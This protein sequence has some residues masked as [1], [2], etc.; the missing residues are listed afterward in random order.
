MDSVVTPSAPAAAASA[1]APAPKAEAPLSKRLVSL[2]VFRGL[3]IAGMLLVNNPG[4][5]SHLYGP[6]AHAPWHGWT[7]TDLIFPFFLF[8]VGV[9]M[10]FSFGKQVERGADRGELMR[11]AAKRSL[12]LFLLG[13][14]LASFPWWGYAWST[15]RIPGVL[16]RIGLVFLLATPLVLWLGRRAQLAVAA[17]LLFGYWAAMMLIPVPGYGAG[18]LSADGNL[19]AYLDRLILGTAHLWKQ[20][21]T[22][23][24]EG[25]LSTV[26]AIATTLLGVQAGYWIR[27]ERSQNA[28]VVGMLAAGAVGIALGLLWDVVFPINKNLWTSSYVVFTA[29]M[30]LVSFAVCYWLVDVKGWQRWS[31]PFMLFGVNAIAVFFA[32]GLGARLLTWIKVGDTSLKGLIYPA[33]TANLS[34]INASLAWALSYVLLWMGIAWWMYRRKIFIKV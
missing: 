13:I 29:G 17:V 10:T 6:L 8:I 2:D 19:A 24:P 21:K 11:G 31:F 32:S 14:V 28:K 30:A 22:W 16:Q 27:S 12:K 1:P 20:S 9:A 34:P 25:L 7:P 3:T 15:V 18:D 33:Y 23:D 5:W 26:P 4:S